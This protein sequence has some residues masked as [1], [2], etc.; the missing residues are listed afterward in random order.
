MESAG[1]RGVSQPSA[2]TAPRNGRAVCGLKEAFQDHCALVKQ[3]L[4]LVDKNVAQAD[5]LL[6]A[7]LDP[8][9]NDVLFPLIRDQRKLAE[10]EFADA[11]RGAEQVV[12]V[13]DVR[14]TWAT[15]FALLAASVLGLLLSRSIAKPLRTSAVGRF[16]DRQGPLGYADSRPLS[17]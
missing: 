3:C 6:E 15:V 1:A 10:Q 16:A 4:A 5:E 8:H 2:A 9:F 11:L 12:D 14:N 13:A 17:Q 7:K